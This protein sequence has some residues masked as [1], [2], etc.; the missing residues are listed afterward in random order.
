MFQNLRQMAP[1]VD[2]PLD[3]LSVK[4]QIFHTWYIYI[5]TRARL[6]QHNFHHDPESRYTIVQ[7][8]ALAEPIELIQGACHFPIIIDN[9]WIIISVGHFE[10]I[11]TDTHA[12]YNPQLLFLEF[13]D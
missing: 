6:Q 1:Y 7:Y 9:S 5:C 2:N 10:C 3:P 4:Y 13:R 8:L 12:F 11:T